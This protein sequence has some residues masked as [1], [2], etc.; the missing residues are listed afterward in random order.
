MDECAEAFLE[1]LRVVVG[2]RMRHVG[3]MGAA[4]SGGIDSSSIVGLV[5]K[6]FRGNFANPLATFTLVHEDRDSCLEQRAVRQMQ[7]GGWLDMT[8]IGPEVAAEAWPRYLAAMGTFDEPFSFINGYTDLVVCEAAREQGC[9]VLLDGMSADLLFYW[10]DQSQSF[11]PEHLRHLPGV[12][13]AAFRHRLPGLRR[14]F[15]RRCVSAAL[16]EFA[17]KAYRA[18]RPVRIPDDARLV[19][20]HLLLE[21]IARWRRDRSRSEDDRVEQASLFTCGLLPMAHEGYGQVA[22]AHGIEPRSPYS[23]R[24]MIEFGIR[25][26]RFAK[27]CDGWYKALTRRAMAGILPDEVRWRRDL[28]VHPGGQFR[29]RFAAELA[30]HAPR[31]WSREFIEDR[32]GRWVDA[33]SLEREWSDFEG[34]P[35]PVTAWLLLNLVANA[36]WLGSRQLVDFGTTEA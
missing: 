36:Q 35:D 8:F 17:K 24:R 26:P 25:L 23:D 32:M 27:I 14:T 28:T 13:S 18:A 10:F 22:F 20:R 11:R 6:E 21:L 7:D 9:R 15:L 16:P 34:K 31:V 3:R 2:C 5:R 19:H 33:R 29:K 30:S 12:A 4:L 1:Q